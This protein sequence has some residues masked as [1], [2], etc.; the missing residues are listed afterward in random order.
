MGEWRIGGERQ[1][2]LSL[3]YVVSCL[4]EGR[5]RHLYVVSRLWSLRDGTDS[6]NMGMRGLKF[7]EFSCTKHRVVSLSGP[8]RVVNNDQVR[9]TAER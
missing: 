7:E 9:A 6:E 1:T 2:I 3:V 4:N 5:M 8:A